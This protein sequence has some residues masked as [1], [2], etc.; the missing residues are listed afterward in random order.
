MT[1]KCSLCKE[2]FPLEEFYTNKKAKDGK[3]TRCKTCCLQQNNPIYS[4]V[5][6]NLTDNNTV[7]HTGSLRIKLDGAFIVI[8]DIEEDE[9][10]IYNSSFVIRIVSS[11]KPK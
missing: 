7:E 2:E 5:L 6:V 4:N 9:E 3:Q 11:S 10:Y 8:T 1:K